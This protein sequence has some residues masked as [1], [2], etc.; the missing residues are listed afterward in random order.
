[1][2]VEEAAL[3]NVAAVERK[4]DMKKKIIPI[5]HTNSNTSY[6]T[7]KAPPCKFYLKTGKCRFGERCKLAHD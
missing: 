5:A 6:T 1:M 7:P 2:E 3:G 4:G